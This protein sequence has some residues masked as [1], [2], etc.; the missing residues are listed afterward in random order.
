VKQ[1]IEVKKNTP[2]D[3]GVFFV[4]NWTRLNTDFLFIYIVGFLVQDIME[5]DADKHGWTRIL[6][7]L[8]C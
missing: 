7:I 4:N 5:W 8:H 6:L 3:A 1:G 2:V